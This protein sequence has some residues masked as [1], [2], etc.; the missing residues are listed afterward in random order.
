MNSV[1]NTALTQQEIGTLNDW[2]GFLSFQE[3]FLLWAMLDTDANI[4]LLDT[5]NQA[6]KN[7]TIAKHYVMRLLGMHP[8][9]RKNMRPDTP[10]RVLRFAAETLPTEKD[11]SG[12]TRNTIYPAFKRFLP[13]GLIKKD[14]TFRSPK[15][16]LYDPQGGPEITVEFTSYNQ[17]V[18][19]QAGHQRWSI[20][21]DEHSPHSFFQEQIP[22][23][24]AAN[25]DLVIGLTPTEGVT[26]EY[27]ELFE[28][29]Q[30]M[31]NS[32][33]LVNYLKKAHNMSLSVRDELGRHTNIAVIRAATDDNPTLD[34]KVIQEMMSRYEGGEYEMRRFGL[35]HQI[36]GVIFKEFENRLNTREQFG[37][38]VSRNE[39]FQD[40][41]PYE[42]IHA[43][44]ID[45]H[46][47]VN[48]ACGWMALSK[49]NEAFVYDEYNP[50]PDRMVTLEIVR[51]V[52]H[53]SGDHRFVVNLIDPLAQ[54]TQPN[55]GLTPVDDINRA[56]TSFRREGLG[57]GG[58]W[59]SWDTKNERGRDV[60]KER[61]KNSRLC[62]RPFNNRIVKN[63]RESY[64]P[65]LWVLDNCQMT[66]H[67][68]KNWRWQQW[69]DRDALMTK[70][71][72]NKPEDRHSHFP[73]MIECLFK[74]P[75]LSMISYRDSVIPARK[76]AYD[77]T[78][79]VRA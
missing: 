1:G 14:I 75:A 27:E 42:W 24:I 59:Q 9:E 44:G 45:F 43:R 28:K 56:F 70:D 69:S 26:W 57:T 77:G 60:I 64:L 79:R 25:G 5:G 19:S 61:L 54:V 74:H 31:Y 20:Y 66:A 13:N 38:I 29:A 8:I 46:P 39:Y 72:K 23:L 62:G 68:M 76:S 12:E 55:S 71:E 17:A 22:R 37:H 11:E 65:T 48:W 67:A 58:Y 36:T 4:I 51:E 73:V 41:I 47:H 15:M 18:Q 49:Y 21:L 32:P 6:G 10:V 7:A 53:R 40:G 34:K 30:W 33:R 50:S 52:A 16:V 78:M 2:A 63:G 3:N 35:F